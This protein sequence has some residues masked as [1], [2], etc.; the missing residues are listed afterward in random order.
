MNCNRSVKKKKK[1]KKKQEKKKKIGMSLYVVFE[2]GFGDVSEKCWF[3]IF[4]FLKLLLFSCFGCANTGV[5][6]QG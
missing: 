3:V 6:V 5:F 4:I 1:K 2:V